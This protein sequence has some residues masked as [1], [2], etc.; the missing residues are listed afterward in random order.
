M[1]PLA[2]VTNFPTRLSHLH[3]HIALNFPI[4]IICSIWPVWQKKSLSN[5]IIFTILSSISFSDVSRCLLHHIITPRLSF[6]S[7]PFCQPQYQ[8]HPSILILIRIFSTMHCNV[9]SS[10]MFRGKITVYGIDNTEVPECILIYQ[11]YWFSSNRILKFQFIVPSQNPTNHPKGLILT[12]AFWWTKMKILTW[13][14]FDIITHSNIFRTIKLRKVTII[15]LV[16]LSTFI[17]WRFCWIF[18]FWCIWK[19]WWFWWIWRFY[20]I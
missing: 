6:L 9:E 19:M 18:W 16:F 17:F 4:G 10:T 13:F 12:Y 7:S 8:P 15:L 20:W 14:Y 3:C 1:A 2:L 5:N 11:K